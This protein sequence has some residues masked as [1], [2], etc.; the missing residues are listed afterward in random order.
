MHMNEKLL[1]YIWQYQLFNKTDIKTSDHQQL[2]IIQ[3]GI[4]NKNQ[5]PDFLESRIKLNN[6]LWVGSIEIHINS[7]DWDLHNHSED[8]H[9]NNVILHVVWNFDPN[10]HFPFPT[11]CLKPLVPKLLLSKY[12]QLHQMSTFIH[13]EKNVHQVEDIIWEKWKE[14]LVVERLELKSMGIY[15]LLKKANGNWEEMS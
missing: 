14:R 10:I 8:E 5:G 1:Q 6:T 4:L 11:I 15:D 12:D 3:P 13:C 2:Q 7:A 9:Y